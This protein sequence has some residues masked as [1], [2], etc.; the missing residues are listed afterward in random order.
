MAEEHVLAQK[1]LV[2]LKVGNLPY[3]TDISWELALG[4]TTLLCIPLR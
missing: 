3:G 2:A 1:F 4:A